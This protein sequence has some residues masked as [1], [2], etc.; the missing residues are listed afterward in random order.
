MGVGNAKIPIGIDGIERV[1]HQEDDTASGV[2][3]ATLA[4]RPVRL[5][6]AD[7]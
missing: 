1:A 6:A 7:V 3:Q 2:G 5:D 4:F